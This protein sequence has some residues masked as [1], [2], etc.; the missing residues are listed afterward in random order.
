MTCYGDNINPDP[1]D[2]HV[3]EHKDGYM[4]RADIRF[5]GCPLQAMPS[6]QVSLSASDSTQGSVDGGGTYDAYTLVTVTATPAPHYH[7]AYWLSDGDT[8]LY[9]SGGRIWR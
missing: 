8:L 2:N 6:F 3:T 5:S 9:N 7:F 4:Y 1:A